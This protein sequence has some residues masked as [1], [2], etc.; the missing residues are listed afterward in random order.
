MV[1]MCTHIFS[2]CIHTHVSDTAKEKM[3]TQSLTHQ[4][5]PTELPV[6]TTECQEPTSTVD[7]D[8]YY[9]NLSPPPT[10]QIIGDNVD[11][12]QKSSHQTLTSRGK[13]HHWFHIVAV[14]DRVVEGD[15]SVTRPLAMAKDL[16][17]HTF[18]PTIE[19]CIKL[20]NEF[21]VLIARVLTHRMTAWKCLKEY[22]PDH[23]PHKY[24]KEMAMQSDIVCYCMYIVN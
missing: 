4:R 11:L 13:D 8:Q 9:L 22:V 19:D 10:F 12:R 18:L 16:K 5:D 20:N 2:P 24:S 14:K 6:K 15:I 17:L 3:A 7:G 1:S 21:V 23:I